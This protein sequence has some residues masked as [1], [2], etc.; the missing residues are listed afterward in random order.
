MGS[1][2]ELRAKLYDAIT[3][4]MSDQTGLWLA[5]IENETNFSGIGGTYVLMDGDKEIR[6]LRPT[7][8][9]YV[10][11]KATSHLLLDMTLLSLPYLNSELAFDGFEQKVANMRVLIDQS[12]Q[13]IIEDQ[14]LS[15]ETQKHL[16][17]ILNLTK[18]YIDTCIK[19]K[20]V[21]IEHYQ[22]FQNNIISLIKDNVW[23]A[24]KIQVNETIEALTQL[25]SEYNDEWNNIHALITTIWPVSEESAREQ[26]LRTLIS[27][28]D[29]LHVIQNISDIGEI[30]T[31]LG[32]KM[33]DRYLQ[34]PGKDKHAK[35]NTPLASDGS[36]GKRCPI[37]FNATGVKQALDEDDTSFFITGQHVT[38]RPLEQKKATNLY[39][40]MVSLNNQMRSDYLQTVTTLSHNIP[41]LFIDEE[42]FYKE[43]YKM[44]LTLMTPG[45]EN[46]NFEAPQEAHL[47]REALA[48]L[49]NIR[50]LSSPNSPTPLDDKAIEQLADLCSEIKEKIATCEQLDPRVKNNLNSFLIN[51]I[52]IL[53][54]KNKDL[55]NDMSQLHKKLAPQLELVHCDMM[56]IYKEYYK[57]LLDTIDTNNLYV[58]IA[59]HSYIQTTISELVMREVMGPQKAMTHIISCDNNKS[60]KD[61]NVT[62]A[63]ILFDRAVAKLAFQQIP[64]YQVA[65]STPI[66]LMA[67]DVKNAVAQVMEKENQNPMSQCPYARFFKNKS[68]KELAALNP[69]GQ[70]IPGLSS[71][72]SK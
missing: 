32:R 30:K 5:A 9:I 3:Q 63:R 50:L 71:N 33:V 16:S 37:D 66:D 68:Q 28:D 41:I 18:N 31:Q 57:E 47:I 23:N 7:P 52:D 26:I 34:A 15:P 1:T 20:Q 11:W 8:N 43:P 4:H 46:I 27:D 70:N 13:L 53:N 2:L 6:R 67:G 49:D 21:S 48:V 14:L 17:A 58:F 36:A 45:K 40:S 12:L 38:I 62:V 59:S 29:N 55:I 24:S 69:H 72:K 22:E 60:E 64:S 42:A 56:Q 54:S 39:D 10:Y 61:A 35:S 51:E 25:K 65:L 44:R 19:T